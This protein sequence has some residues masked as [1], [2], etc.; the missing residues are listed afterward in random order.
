M[1][2]IS[3][4][5]G[6]TL[7][8]VLVTAVVL[9]VGILGVA[10]LQ[11]YGIKNTHSAN[12]RIQASYLANSIVD[13]MRANPQATRAGLYDI[14]A[15]GTIVLPIPDCIG[16]DK[17]CTPAELAR[18]DL[19]KWK[20]DMN[21]LNASGDGYILTEI[22]PAGYAEVTVTVGWSDPL[23]KDATRSEFVL[24]VRV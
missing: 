1:I 24:R 19:N 17:N 4:Q 18:F 15:N 3:N 13:N 20:S 11:I 2:N 7:I 14:V 10:G 5:K 6:F 21:A 16:E 9:G 23:T 8:E 12:E 22:N